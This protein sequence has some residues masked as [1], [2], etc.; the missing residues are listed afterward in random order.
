MAQPPVRAFVEKDVGKE[1][2]DKLFAAIAEQ[3]K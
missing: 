3:K 2:V 1:W